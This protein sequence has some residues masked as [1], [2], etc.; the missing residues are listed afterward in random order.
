MLSKTSIAL[1]ASAVLANGVVAVDLHHRHAH[2]HLHEKKAVYYLKTEIEVVTEWVTV[3]YDPNAPVSMFAPGQHSEKV[4]STSSTSTSSSSSTSSTTSTTPTSTSTSSIFVAPVPTTLVTS[5]AAPAPA[6]ETPEINI[7]V[8]A[9]VEVAV[10]TPAAAAVVS[11]PAAEAEPATT[12]TAA[13]AVSN[14]GKR[15]FAYNDATLA[16]PLLGGK[17]KWG[18]NWGQSRDG[19]DDDLEYV[20]MLWGPASDHSSTWSA[21]AKKAIAAGSTNLLSFNECDNIGQANISPSQA[22]ADHITYMNPFS[23][24]A[25]IGSPAITNS[26]ADGEG[27]SWLNSWIE[28]CNGKCAFDF[29]AFHWYSPADPK[30]FLEH[31]T[32][33]H[34][35]CDNKPV[36]LTEFA[37]FGDDDTINDFLL[38]VMDQ[39]DNN[40]TYSFIERYSFFMLSDGSLVNGGAA[41]VYG[42]S[43]AFS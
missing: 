30:E 16:A 32:K 39:M 18:Y 33:V 21:N 29:C 42:K 25:R 22:A 31:A 35:A 24:Q 28:A 2:Q 10:T 12:T 36:W 41:S 3:T 27:I 43:Y 4:I 20:P 15:G 40:A 1:L 5:S 9:S 11:T 38:E 17:V 23:G 34:E 7:Q 13:V 26:G 8:A 6:A 37:P 14:S 19:L